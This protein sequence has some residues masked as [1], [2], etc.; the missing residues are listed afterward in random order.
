M[1]QDEELP[2][3]L[4]MPLLELRERQLASC[5]RTMRNVARRLRDLSFADKEAL[6]DLAQRLER[7]RAGYTET[8]EQ[9]ENGEEDGTD[10]SRDE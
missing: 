10:T 1:T 3:T 9:E 6:A 7:V 5:T 8:V 2:E 4:D